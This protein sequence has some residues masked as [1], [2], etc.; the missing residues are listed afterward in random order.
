[1][2]PLS[3]AIQNLWIPKKQ[4]KL[5]KFLKLQEVSKHWR[6]ETVWLTDALHEANLNVG[7]ILRGKVDLKEA[8]NAEQK[9]QHSSLRF[10]FKVG[11]IK[12]GYLLR[13]T[14][15]LCAILFGEKKKG[16]HN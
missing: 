1:M 9:I 6:S 13:N 2:P 15:F 5:Q 14:Q 12:N 16:N 10:F 3:S 4:T 11:Y 7:L 8:T